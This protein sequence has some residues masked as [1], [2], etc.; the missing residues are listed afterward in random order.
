MHNL[1]FFPVHSSLRPYVSGY[2][3]FE[4]DYVVPDSPIFSPKGTAAL[5]IPIEV[6]EGN[7]LAYPTPLDRHY[8]E[9]GV[10][11]L[12]GQMSRVGYAYNVG[13]FKSFIIVFTPTGLFYFLGGPV[14]KLTD[15]IVDL[16]QLGLSGL[17]EQLRTLFA[18]SQCPNGWVTGL[19]AL[20]SAWFL[21]R[22]AQKQCLD[23]SSI[24]DEIIRR[25]G[26]LALDA[27]GCGVRVSKRTFQIHFK[28]QVGISPKLFCRIVR[29]NALIDAMHAAEKFDLLEL[30]VAHGYTDGSHLHKDFKDFSGLT[31]R[32]YLRTHFVINQGVERILVKNKGR[33]SSDG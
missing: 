17:K 10:P 22:G 7:F 5:T 27:K 1:T 6:S 23:V 24:C 18:S 9:A 11:L 19:D 4:Y 14:D 26:D 13:R 31:P 28:Q 29:F 16:E 25:K 32:Q 3:L 21:R 33:F 30:V 2:M 15:K 12:F 8:F 20:L